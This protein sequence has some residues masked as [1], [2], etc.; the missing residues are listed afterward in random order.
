M[1]IKINSGSYGFGHTWTLEAYGRSFFL[2]QDVKVCSR[3]LGVTPR[4]MIHQAGIMQYPCDMSSEVNRK[5]I[6][7][8]ICK[9]V[10][11]NRSNVS[12]LD[13]WSLAVE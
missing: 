3:L 13:D 5:K 8:Y 6:A 7:R 2:G 11:L 4:T 1:T 9:E 12:K 10:G